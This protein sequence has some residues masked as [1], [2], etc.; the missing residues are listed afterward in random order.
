MRP[1]DI[2]I[3]EFTNEQTAGDAASGTSCAVEQVRNVALYGFLAFRQGRQLP[4]VFTGHATCQL[5]L[6]YQLVV[7]GHNT[8][9][10]VAQRDDY[11]TG[12]RCYI[13]NLLGTHLAGIPDCVRQ[14]H[15][16][17][18][19]GGNNLDGLAVGCTHDVAGALRLAVR[20]IF[21]AGQHTDNVAFQA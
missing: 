17:F 5:N 14:H 9:G 2:F 12:E 18:R 1:R 3:N 16:S 21:R 20:H 7:I 11:R 13:N 4:V 10:F 6:L 15:A 19:I 8:A